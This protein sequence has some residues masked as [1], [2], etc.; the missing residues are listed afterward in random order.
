MMRSII[1]TNLSLI[2][3]STV[4][5]EKR[6]R[7][8]SV[9]TELERNENVH[10]AIC[11]MS[12]KTMTVATGHP[13]CSRNGHVW[14][15]F[16]LGGFF[17]TSVWHHTYTEMVSWLRESFNFHWQIFGYRCSCHLGRS[18]WREI[19]LCDFWKSVIVTAYKALALIFPCD[20]QS[21][22]VSYNAAFCGRL[23][24]SRCRDL[25]IF[26]RFVRSVVCSNRVVYR[27]DFR[28][29]QLIASTMPP[30]V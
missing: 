8:L 22:K 30:H 15:I 16:G 1:F 26:C 20:N 9:C 6:G 5:I 14:R 25:E 11:F 24:F 3:R 7:C 18:S 4:V 28:P 21:L 23:W 12:S 2:L 13:N 19:E 29:F 10:W 17:R 27:V